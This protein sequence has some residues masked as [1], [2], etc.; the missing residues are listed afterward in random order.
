MDI[1]STFQLEYSNNAVSF[2][3]SMEKEK[4]VV[5]IQS[6]CRRRKKIL[7]HLGACWHH[8]LYFVYLA[9]IL[10]ISRS[11]L[12]TIIY[13]CST[14]RFFKCN[15]LIGSSLKTILGNTQAMLNKHLVCMHHWPWKLLVVVA[16]FSI[17]PFIV[18]LCKWI[19]M[20]NYEFI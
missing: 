4:I 15:W 13:V 12:F 17:F 5:K 14:Y 1:E 8:V 19:G 7:R 9:T 3:F 11:S 2:S 18:R 20:T 10:S 6:V 16:R